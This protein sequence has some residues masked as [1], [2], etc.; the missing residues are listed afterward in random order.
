MRWALL[1][2]LLEVTP[3]QQ[4][5]ARAVTDF[6][7][8]IFD[9]HF[10]SFPVTPGVL[11]LEM[12]N[13]LSGL[14]AKASA[15]EQRGFLVFPVLTMI[16]QCKFRSFLPP[17]TE[18]EVY[19]RLLELR[20]ESAMFSGEVR[21]GAVRYVNATVVLAFQPDGSAGQGDVTLLTDHVKKEFI[22]LKSPWMPESDRDAAGRTEPGE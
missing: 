1:S 18:I 16:Q 19:S 13:Q 2:E 12:I 22:R 15:W 14:L 17:N 9:N 11:A 20:P 5:R 21:R 3:G 7:S 8:E 6:P 4:A 10:P